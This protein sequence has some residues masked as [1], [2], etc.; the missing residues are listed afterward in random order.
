MIFRRLPALWGAA[1]TW[2]PGA[3][4]QEAT[5]GVANRHLNEVQRNLRAALKS[6]NNEEETEAKEATS[7]GRGGK[8]K[9]LRHQLY[10]TPTPPQQA[11]WE[12]VQL[13]REQGLSLRAIA[14]N[15]GMA[16]NTAKKYAVA[17]SPP[18]K[19]LSAKERAKA[20]APAESLMASD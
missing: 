3:Q 4:P 5:D 19:K 11:R 10:R 6:A 12:A 8:G 7:K 14:R 20:D 15:L 9:L 1:S 16:K 13:A 17:E 18:T 2:S